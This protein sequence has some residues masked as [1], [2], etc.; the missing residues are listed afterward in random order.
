MSAKRN[1]LSRIQEIF[2]VI[3]QTQQQIDALGLD[4]RRF[5]NPATDSDELIAEGLM[6]RVFRITEELGRIED[7]TAEKYGFDTHG[8]K[9]VRNR[10]AHVYG[11]VDKAIVWTVISSEFDDIL[12]ACNEFA[13]DL[14]VLL[15]DPEERESS[16]K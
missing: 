9:G 15:E 11:E 5:I 6:N 10:L 1:D 7:S 8:A 4:E 12:R 16:S 14:G 13:S 3:T 2:D